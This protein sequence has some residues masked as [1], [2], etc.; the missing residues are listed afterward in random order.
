M[1]NFLYF[2]Y[3]HKE[4]TCQQI[5]TQRKQPCSWTQYGSDGLEDSVNTVQSLDV[6]DFCVQRAVIVIDCMQDFVA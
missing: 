2:A 5:S 1:P 6:G 3:E 4:V